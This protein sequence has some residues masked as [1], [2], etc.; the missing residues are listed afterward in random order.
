MNDKFIVLTDVAYNSKQWFK[1]NIEVIENAKTVKVINGPIIKSDV[2]PL[3]LDK[4]RKIFKPDS[5]ESPISLKEYMEMTS[6]KGFKFYTSIII[7]GYVEADD[8]DEAQKIA[9]SIN[10]SNIKDVLTDTVVTNATIIE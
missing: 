5:T 2:K 10:I 4:A 1:K 9:N 6:S 8:W 3:S 7:E